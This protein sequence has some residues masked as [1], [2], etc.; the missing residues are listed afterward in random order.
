MAD[1]PTLT[2]EAGALTDEQAQVLFR[3]MCRTFGWAGVV[4]TREDVEEEAERILTDE[5][6]AK[7]QE[8]YAWRNTLPATLCEEGWK[9][10]SDALKEIRFKS[11]P[12][13][14]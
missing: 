11:L 1:K 9:C 4:F 7:V 13:E 14:E 2:V 5:E 12:Q 10:V 3:S 6:W 8:T